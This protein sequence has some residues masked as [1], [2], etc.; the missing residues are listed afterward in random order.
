MDRRPRLMWE[1]EGQCQ[2]GRKT[3]LAGQCR[4]CALE[5]AEK[6]HVHRERQ[7]AQE[8]E[9][10]IEHY[11]LVV[12]A[13][14][15]QPVAQMDFD[16][17]FI[18][19]WLGTSA[20]VLM[21]RSDRERWE[22]DRQSYETYGSGFR[23]KPMQKTGYEVIISS[24]TLVAVEAGMPVEPILGI[25]RASGILL[26]ARDIEQIASSSTFLNVRPLR[27][28]DTGDHEAFMDPRVRTP[29]GWTA[30]DKSLSDPWV[31][32][33]SSKPCVGKDDTQEFIG[34]KPSSLG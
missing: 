33:D 25:M 15:S 4:K 2:C 28:F 1:H 20:Q 17:Y 30:W 9:L 32:K 7:A 23:D 29:G 19:A 27:S 24:Q 21:H 10:Q 11:E 8:A 3:Y 31:K 18:V 22:T 6:R 14:G 13:P 26:T 34:K 5:D 16:D 12:P